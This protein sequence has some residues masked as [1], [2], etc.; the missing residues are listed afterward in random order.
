MRRRPHHAD[1][2]LMISV[3]ERKL[4]T[5]NPAATLITAP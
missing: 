2:D 4:S 3:V 5:R 1:V